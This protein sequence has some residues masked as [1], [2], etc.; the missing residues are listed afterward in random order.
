MLS[1][2]LLRSGWRSSSAGLAGC[3]GRKASLAGETFCLEGAD[4][5]VRVVRKKHVLLWILNLKKAMVRNGD[6]VCLALVCQ[7]GRCRSL[8]RRAE[9][10]FGGCGDDSEWEPGI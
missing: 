1:A 2:A 5:F 10:S 7:A 6:P 9:T 4:D 3:W 8:S